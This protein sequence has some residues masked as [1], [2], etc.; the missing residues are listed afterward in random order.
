[1]FLIVELTFLG[2]QKINLGLYS[3]N[4]WSQRLNSIIKRWFFEFLIEKGIDINQTDKDGQNALHLASHGGH[5]E[6][7]RLLIEKKL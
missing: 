6:V 4:F 5:K 2:E 7:V 3:I 1:M